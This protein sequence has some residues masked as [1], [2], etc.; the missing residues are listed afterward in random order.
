MPWLI[1]SRAGEASASP[2]AAFD[3][4]Q[5]VFRSAVAGHRGH[6]LHTSLVLALLMWCLKKT[7]LA[8]AMRETVAPSRLDFRPSHHFVHITSEKLPE[9]LVHGTTSIEEAAAHTPVLA[10]VAVS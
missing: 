2:V 1:R 6:D 7:V 5:D 8:V 10:A 9:K 4:L 3:V